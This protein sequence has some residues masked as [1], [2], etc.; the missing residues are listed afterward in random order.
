MKERILIPPRNVQALAQAMTK[1]TDDKKLRDNLAN[2]LKKKGETA[3][4]KE[5]T[6]KA[7]NLYRKLV[8]HP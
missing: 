7:Y 4:W 3:H 8:I 5:V 1:L 2:N 6:P